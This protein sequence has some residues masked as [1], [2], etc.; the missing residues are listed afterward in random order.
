M[1]EPRIVFAPDAVPHPTKIAVFSGQD[2]PRRPEPPPWQPDPA[3]LLGLP[4]VVEV[5]GEAMRMQT[6]PYVRSGT[7]W[8]IDRAALA[9]S[10]GGR[11]G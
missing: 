10:E 6:S 5:D 8:V 7:V 4:A 3:L 1:I 11:S 2:L 9:E